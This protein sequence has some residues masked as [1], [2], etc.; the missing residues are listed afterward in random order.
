[1]FVLPGYVVEQVLHRG[2]ETTI[3][4]ATRESDGLPVAVK[5]CAR[6]IPTPSD[7]ARL[8]YEYEL[9]QEL[10]HTGI[11]RAIGLETTS[12][13]PALI[14]ELLKGTPLDEYLLSAKLTLQEGI[15]LAIKITT[16]LAAIHSHKI[17]HKDIKPHH[18]FFDTDSGEVCLFDFGIAT[19]LG[20]IAMQAGGSH[21]TRRNARVSVAGTDGA[22]ESVAR[23]AQRSVF[24]GSSSIRTIYG[25]SSVYIH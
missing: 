10:T 4:R 14:L 22:G 9:L 24:V 18:V 11:V 16:A 21:R 12:A 25:G 20:H 3:F 17:V 19:R 13:G 23:S 5:L 6:A 8:R 7:R 1:M 2:R 15:A